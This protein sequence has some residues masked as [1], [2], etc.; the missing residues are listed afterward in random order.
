MKF[1]S[2][3]ECEVGDI[4]VSLTNK[5]HH[6]NIGDIFKIITIDGGCMYYKEFTNSITSSDWRHAT[7]NEIRAYEQGIKNI[8]DIPQNNIGTYEIY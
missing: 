1:T 2:W 6:R 4:I 3:N 5:G 8:N 7:G